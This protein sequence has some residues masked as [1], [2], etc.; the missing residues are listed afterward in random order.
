[1]L[2]E[3]HLIEYCSPT[4]ASLKTASLFNHSYVSEAELDE[5]LKLWN[6]RLRD[7]GVILLDLCRRENKALIYVYRRSRLQADLNQPGVKGF[8]KNYG[9]EDVNVDEAVAGMRRRMAEGDGFPHEI[10]VFLGYPLGDVIGFIE[11]EGKNCICKGYWKVYCDECE[12]I[13]AFSRYKKCKTTYARLWEQGRT[14]R[15]L[16]VAV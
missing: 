2:L 8:L 15:Q 5:Q 1:M 9:Y 4:L 13:K 12:A 3:R 10:G 6:G 7:K 16:T 11:N 14:V